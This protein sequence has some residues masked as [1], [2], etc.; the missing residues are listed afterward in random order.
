MDIIDR[1]RPQMRA[2]LTP[3]E[4]F[5]KI[6]KAYVEFREQKVVDVILR[7]Q[8][9]QSLQDFQSKQQNLSREVANS[10][11]NLIGN[12]NLQTVLI[13]VALDNQ[14]CHIRVLTN[15]GDLINPLEYATTGTGEMHA[16]QSLIGAKYKKTEDLDAATYLV[17]EA[18]RRAEVAPGV[19]TMTDMI[20]LSHKEDG[21][22]SERKLTEDD[23]NKL[24]EVYN[25]VNAR[26]TS[27]IK[28]ILA[29][30]SFH[31]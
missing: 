8:G 20:V 14:K 18:K 2:N 27:K 24:S 9:F 19:G 15:P 12:A 3:S 31:I 26:D 4:K 22:I 28:A 6:K 30:K 5:E 17:Y 21:S 16:T 23:L 13:L 25:E 7:A 1:A 11:Q 10:I 29:E